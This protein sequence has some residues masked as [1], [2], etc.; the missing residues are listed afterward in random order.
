MGKMSSIIVPDGPSRLPWS[1]TI[2]ELLDCAVSRNPHKVY[3]YYQTELP[4][5]RSWPSVLPVR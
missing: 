2:G 4:S 3:L 5:L 1:M